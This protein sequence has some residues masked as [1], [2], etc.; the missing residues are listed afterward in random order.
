MCGELK[1][2]MGDRVSA[3]VCTSVCEGYVKVLFADSATIYHL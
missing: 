2:V 1:S 3:G